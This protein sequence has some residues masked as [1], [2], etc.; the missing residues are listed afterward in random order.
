MFDETANTLAVSLPRPILRRVRA[1][2]RVADTTSVLKKLKGQL[3]GGPG[4]GGGGFE[5]DSGGEGGSRQ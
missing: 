4:D 5:V 2:V 1:I 3:A